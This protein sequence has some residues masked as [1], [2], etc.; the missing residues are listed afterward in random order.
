MSAIR[1][2]IG[3][4]EENVFLQSC[5]S[6]SDMRKGVEAV[7]GDKKKEIQQQAAL[8]KSGVWGPTHSFDSDDDTHM[9]VEHKKEGNSDTTKEETN[10]SDSPPRIVSPESASSASNPLNRL[11]ESAVTAMTPTSRSLKRAT[12]SCLY[13]GD[14]V[15]ASDIE[16]DDVVL[17]RSGEI[18]AAFDP[19]RPCRNPTCE[20][21]PPLLLPM[22]TTK[23]S[24]RLPLLT[25]SI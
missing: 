16:P 21:P 5:A 22:T 4:L 15:V 12:S 7:W 14:E 10:S 8:S 9:Q 23:R 2:A 11:Y 25:Q 20:S 13:K 6:S 1:S 3:S 19:C 18:F 17:T 24:S